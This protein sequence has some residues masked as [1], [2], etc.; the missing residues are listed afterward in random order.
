MQSADNGCRGC[1]CLENVKLDAFE[2][3][4]LDLPGKQD[5]EAMRGSG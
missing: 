1:G 3:V 2:K 5:I 4:R